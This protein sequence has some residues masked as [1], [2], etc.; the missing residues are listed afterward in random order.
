M[1][2]S[3]LLKHN[4]KSHQLVLCFQSRN[5]TLLHH[6]I[7]FLFHFFEGKF[8]YLSHTS[9]SARWISQTHFGGHVASNNTNPS[10]LFVR[11]LLLSF[12]Q[13]SP[14]EEIQLCSFLRLTMSITRWWKPNDR[15]ASWWKHWIIMLC[16]SVKNYVQFKCHFFLCN[17]QVRKRVS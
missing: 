2:N 14:V 5:I 1:K 10:S 12:L 13:A 4:S 16:S 9:F 11:K 17:L 15:F 3:H 7:F 6:S 8:V